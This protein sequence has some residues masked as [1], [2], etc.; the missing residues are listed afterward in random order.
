MSAKRVYFDT[1][2]SLAFGSISGTYAAVGSPLTVEPRI[3][4]FSN[5]TQGDMIISV[6][7]TNSSGNLFVAAGGFKLFDFTAN[8]VSGKDDNFVLP[9]GTQFY[10]K[11]ITAPVSGAFYIDIVY[12]TPS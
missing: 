5:S 7:N 9:I 11:Q 3:I 8:L 12:G 2:R 6:D 4:C 10:V 1:L